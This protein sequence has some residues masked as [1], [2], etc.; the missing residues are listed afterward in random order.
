M[1]CLAAEQP[2]T[3]AGP[4]A[5]P[6]RRRAARQPSEANDRSSTTACEATLQTT[7]VGRAASRESTIAQDFGGQHPD[8]QLRRATDG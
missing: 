8:R 1:R 5:Q 4:L 3:A 6:C 7:D 2:L